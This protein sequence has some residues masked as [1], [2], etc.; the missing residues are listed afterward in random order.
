MEAFV[1]DVRYSLRTLLKA[2]AFAAVAVL[3][4]A[5]G[6]GAC[7]A[8]F[9]VVHAV[10]LRPL[11]FK[12]PERLV[13]IENV[14]SGGLSARTT[15]VD[16]FLEW[17]AQ[18]NS[19]EELAAYFAFFDYSRYTLIGSGEPRRLRGVGISKNFLAILG[20]QPLLGRGFTDEECVWNGRKAAML[21]HAFWRQNF[22]SDP[23]IVGRSITLNGDPTEIVGVLPPSF[24]FDSVFAPGT[25][26]ELLLP[27]PLTEETARW[28]NTI[29]AIGRLKRSATIQQAQAEFDVISRQVSISHPE[30]GGFGAR[31]SGLETSIRGGFRQSLF[32]LFAAVGCV[33][34]IAC[35]NL[36]NLLLARANAR[37]REFA[38]RV[39]L[40]A[41]RWHLIRQTLTESL[42]L[43]FG[44]CVLG[45]PLAFVATQ[46]LSRL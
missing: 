20:V 3:T 7:T 42:L 25:E 19:F 45:V 29:F 1:Q 2:P 26:V 10:L 11:P 34:L 46:G 23:K 4:L 9:S 31:M 6:I 17:R 30:R 37:R 27:F 36:S 39:A 38:V 15:R 32:M 12:E 24:D 14:G 40:G 41:T 21:S 33:L 13:W 43:A 5:L 22:A 18:N 8:M 28:G 16:N 35:V 44:G